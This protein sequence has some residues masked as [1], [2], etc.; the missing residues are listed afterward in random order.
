MP[1]LNVFFNYGTTESL[2]YHPGV[3][4]QIHLPAIPRI[5]ET[6]LISE[7]TIDEFQDWIKKDTKLLKEYFPKWFHNFRKH[8]TF[9]DELIEEFSLHEA[10]VVV[11]VF[12]SE[13]RKEVSIVLDDEMRK[14]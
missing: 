2:E 5:G 13:K 4:L 14:K 8:E 12:Y 1:T 6:V 9:C 3:F 11:D 7:E 10:M